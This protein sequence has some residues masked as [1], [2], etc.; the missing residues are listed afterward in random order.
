MFR[1]RRGAV[2]GGA[3]ITFE[4]GEGAGKSTQAR[5]LA[6]RL[7]AAGHAVTLTREPGG[8]PFA[9]RLRAALLSEDGRALT[10]SQQAVMFAAARADHVAAVIAPAL[11]A[12]GIVVCDRF[13]DSTEAY[14]GSAGAPAGLLAALGLVAAGATAPDLTLVL[15]CPAELGRERILPRGTLDPFERADDEA[16]EARRAAFLAIAR[17]E[18]HRCVVLDACLPADALAAAVW[19]AVETRIL[20]APPS[21]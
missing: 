11:A 21:A 10:A 9:E 20:A 7:R 4:G 1:Q 14:Q 3:F 13:A 18:A 12:G 8:S 2:I 5:R 17:R 15:D 6:E 16:Q 19:A